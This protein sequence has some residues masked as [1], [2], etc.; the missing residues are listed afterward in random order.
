MPRKSPMSSV[1]GGI[2]FR[3]CNGCL[4]A[5]KVTMHGVV[6]LIIPTLT[7]VKFTKEQELRL[8]SK[9]TGTSRKKEDHGCKY[10]KS[11]TKTEEENKRCPHSQ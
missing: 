5:K 11:M 4:K 1:V 3:L 2:V 9:L 8:G 7:R 10:P 6:C